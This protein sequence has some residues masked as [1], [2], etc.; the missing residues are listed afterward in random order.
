MIDFSLQGVW[1]LYAYVRLLVDHC[2][3]ARTIND[4]FQLDQNRPIPLFQ[5]LKPY[6]K[7]Q[8]KGATLVAPFL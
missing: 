7:P 2:L 8:K 6:L 5:I 1:S 3:V 4:Q